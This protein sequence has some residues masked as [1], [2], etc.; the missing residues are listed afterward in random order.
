MPPRRYTPRCTS[1][2][3]TCKLSK[4]I[5]SHA[6]FTR[7]SILN[8]HVS[9]LDLEHE[10]C[11]ASCR[12]GPLLDARQ[13]PTLR[14]HKERGSRQPAFFVSHVSC[15]PSKNYKNHFFRPTFK[16]SG[17]TGRDVFRLVSSGTTVADEP[18]D[19]SEAIRRTKKRSASNSSQKAHNAESLTSKLL[20]PHIK[21]L[22]RRLPSAVYRRKSVAWSATCVR[23][24]VVRI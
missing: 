20:H 6:P 21:S 22:L 24:P 1:R 4:P 7:P 17:L 9:L 11:E 5:T 15:K 23:V 3:S 18:R 10:R 14:P 8:L 16:H 13:K 2:P 12:E 19:L